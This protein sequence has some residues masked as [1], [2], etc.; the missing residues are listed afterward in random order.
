MRY[1]SINSVDIGK[2]TGAVVS[3]DYLKKPT[4]VTSNDTDVVIDKTEPSKAYVYNTITSL[5]INTVTKSTVECTIEFTAGTG[6]LL[7]VPTSLNTVGD[8]EF[9]DGKKYIMSIYNNVMAVGEIN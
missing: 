3:G 4:I 5:T 1:Y 7:E 6:F 2:N 8:I 9:V